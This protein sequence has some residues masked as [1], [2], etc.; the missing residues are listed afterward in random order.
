[1]GKNIILGIGAVPLLV[2]TAKNTIFRGGLWR[3]PPLKIDFQKI[4]N[5]KIEN[6]KIKKYCSQPATIELQFFDEIC[7][8]ASPGVR[9]AYLKPRAYI[10]LHYTIQSLITL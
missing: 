10:P 2:L 1:V 7:T 9:T 3:D 8:L 5:K 4:K 6:S